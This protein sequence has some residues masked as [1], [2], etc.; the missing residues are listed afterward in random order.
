MLNNKL[1]SILSLLIV[2]CLCLT[3]LSACG[4]NDNIGDISS[5][6]EAEENISSND[7]KIGIASASVGT[8]V[9]FGTYEQDN[10][11]SNGAEDIEWIVLENDSDKMMLISK[12]VLDGKDYNDE[13]GEF[14]WETCGLR[15]WLN[16]V[17][18]TTAFNEKEKTT[19]CE[20]LIS[21]PDNATWGTEGGN[22]TTDKVFLLSIDEVNKYFPTE[23]S[24]LTTGTAYGN[25]IMTTA[26]DSEYRFWWLRSPGKVSAN[27]AYV[28]ADGR[29][30]DVG[31]VVNVMCFG[32]RPVIYVKIAD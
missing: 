30:V 4:N 6:N 27:A 16:E 20:T 21:N 5:N 14:T 11:T 3:T 8:S 22:D 15:T 31:N 12:Y 25:T 13:Y 29:L 23:E 28:H 1:K 24:H 10:N 2:L 18:L 9:F 32:V 19:V 26:S 17:F 7:E